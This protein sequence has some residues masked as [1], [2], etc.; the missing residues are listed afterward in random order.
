MTLC[1]PVTQ[2]LGAEARRPGHWRE[3]LLMG[4]VCARWTSGCTFYGEK[5]VG[6]CRP[7]DGVGM[8]AHWWVPRRWGGAWGQT[9]THYQ[10]DQ[11]S[12]WRSALDSSKPPTSENFSVV[13]WLRLCI[14]NTELPGQGTRSHVPQL[15]ILHAAIK[16]E[17]TACCS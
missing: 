3:D 9:G 6:F 1:K 17:D 13:Q 12:S 2:P 14:P 4:K 10:P 5:V 16:S 15:K 11:G 8:E 7:G